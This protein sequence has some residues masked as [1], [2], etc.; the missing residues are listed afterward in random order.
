MRPFA[1]DPCRIR[2]GHG[3]TSCG[4]EEEGIKCSGSTAWRV[5]WSWSGPG[6]RVGLGWRVF[7]AEVRR[8]G[9]KACCRLPCCALAPPFC[10]RLAVSSAH[11]QLVWLVIGLLHLAEA[12]PNV[13]APLSLSGVIQQSSKSRVKKNEV[14]EDVLPVVSSS[15]FRALRVQS[16]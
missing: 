7:V 6:P 14:D 16:F 9:R 13:P 3:A 1:K 10:D 4:D 5:S 12:P 8:S 15:D 11:L 2:P